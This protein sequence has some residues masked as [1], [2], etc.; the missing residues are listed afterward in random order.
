M[1]EK[2][3]SAGIGF[4]CALAITISWT[5]WHSIWWAIIHGV[6]GWFYVIYYAIQYT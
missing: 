6:L 1:S 2:S 5:A 3:T 4:G